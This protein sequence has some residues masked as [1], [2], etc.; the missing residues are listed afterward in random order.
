MKTNICFFAV[1]Q[2]ITRN[3]ASSD[4]TGF[5]NL[6]IIALASFST[7]Y[8]VILYV[9]YNPSFSRAIKDTIACRTV[10]VSPLGQPDDNIDKT[11]YGGNVSQFARTNSTKF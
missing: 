8:N 4:A 11:D 5:S 10:R 1:F 7:A 6:F 3:D 9:I 2:K